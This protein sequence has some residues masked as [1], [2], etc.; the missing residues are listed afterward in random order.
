MCDD[1]SLIRLRDNMSID[2][3]KVMKFLIS[4]HIYIYHLH[5]RDYAVCSYWVIQCYPGAIFHQRVYL[6]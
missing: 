6:I 5:I 3:K 2:L 1:F 4:E